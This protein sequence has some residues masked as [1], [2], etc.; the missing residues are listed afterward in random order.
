MYS[1]KLLSALERGP[2]RAIGGTV[3]DAQMQM[4]M[5]TTDLHAVIRELGRKGISIQRTDAGGSPTWDV[6][7]SGDE[8]VR[9]QRGRIKGGPWGMKPGTKGRISKVFKPGEGSGW[10]AEF[11]ARGWQPMRVKKGEVE[12]EAMSAEA[13]VNNLLE[14]DFDA[15]V[16]ARERVKKWDAAHGSMQKLW[17][18]KQQ[19]LAK[20]R[21]L[22]RAVGYERALAHV[23]LTR[24]DV[25]HPI[26]GDQIGSVD[27]YKKTHP[28]K[29]CATPS[30]CFSRKA[31]PLK[32]EVCRECGG[33][34][35]TVEVPYSFTELH[36]KY[37]RYMLGVET[38]SGDRVWFNEPLPPTAFMDVP[39]AEAL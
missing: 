23:G 13:I 33:P 20:F 32:A 39:E 6:M 16:K 37:A 31:Q 36:G 5:S 15:H 35:K 25:S 2:V 30:Q 38:N 1:E 26:Y 28:A 14:D 4:L 9:G 17:P 10:D 22:G 12:F 27:N 24:E 11:R 19:A 29:V 34:L 7:E 21:E 18:L 8:F 3:Y